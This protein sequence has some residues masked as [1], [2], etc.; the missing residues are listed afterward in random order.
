[1]YIPQNVPATLYVG[2]LSSLR[3]HEGFGLNE[4]LADPTLIY[5]LP[6]TKFKYVLLIIY[7]APIQNKTLNYNRNTIKQ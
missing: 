2:K 6:I 5:T 7:V 1:M 3:F 4:K